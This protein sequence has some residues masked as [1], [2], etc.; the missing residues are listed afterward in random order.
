MLSD[1]QPVCFL[2]LIPNSVVVALQRWDFGDGSG[3]KHHNAV[4]NPVKF[5]VR[6]IIS[7]SAVHCGNLRCYMLIGLLACLFGST[8]YDNS[9]W[10]RAD[11]LKVSPVNPKPR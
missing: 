6:C 2:T 7:E 3:V 8:D 10:D 1:N 9:V 11:K 5:S 4:C